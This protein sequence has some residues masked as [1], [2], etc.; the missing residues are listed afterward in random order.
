MR[1]GR[2]PT[3]AL[4]EAD[5]ETQRASSLPQRPHLHS[6]SLTQGIVLMAS[7]LGAAVERFIQVPG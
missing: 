1:A 7:A 5:T 2:G 6:V 4:S 3:S